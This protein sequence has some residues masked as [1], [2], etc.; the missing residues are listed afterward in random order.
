M[1]EGVCRR[2]AGECQPGRVAELL[3]AVM[4]RMLMGVGGE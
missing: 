2:G 4:K 1:S 3:D